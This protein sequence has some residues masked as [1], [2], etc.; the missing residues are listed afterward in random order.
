M[1]LQAS[2]NGVLIL[3]RFPVEETRVVDFGDLKV[4]DTVPQKGVI[5]S[6]IRIGGEESR[7]D[8][9]KLVNGSV[10]NLFVTHTQASVTG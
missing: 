8:K 6:R 3:S 7:V 4:E 9:N 5:Y 10:L 2:E 1:R